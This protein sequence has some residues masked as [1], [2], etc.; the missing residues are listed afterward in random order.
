MMDFE[1]L[2]GGGGVVAG[3]MDSIQAPLQGGRSPANA[4]G[5]VNRG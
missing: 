1:T 5:D 4:T 2:I 3:S